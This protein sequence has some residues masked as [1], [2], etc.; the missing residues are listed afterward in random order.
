MKN[1]QLWLI[2]STTEINLQ[3]P[4][5]A[6]YLKPPLEGLTGL[7]D[8]RVAQGNN[9]GKSGGWTG[10]PLYEPR[11]IAATVQ[12]AHPDVAVV[13]QKR[14]DLA[15]LLAEHDLKLR[16]VTEGGTTY[17]TRVK[18]LGAPAPLEQL[19]TRVMIK[20]N[21]KADDPLLYDYNSSGG[22]IV[23]TLP[24]RV[25]TGGF[26]IPFEF[27]LI[28]DGG[29][30]T[31]SVVNSGTSTVSPIITLYGP[32]HEPKVVNQTTNQQIQ[33]LADLSASDVVVMNTALETVTLNGLDIY[34]LLSEE[35]NFI[36]INA[37][38]NQMYLE[39]QNAGDTG[40]AEIEYNSG[41]I[42]T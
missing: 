11:F 3:D 39:S 21:L 42:G 29:D 32:L 37:G 22:G 24:V 33:I 10:K 34:Y 15:T 28:I 4:Q 18:V 36:D 20:V 23:A 14:R 2:G 30:P 40:Y 8:I 6:I 1:T 7:P 41:F 35:S 19:L 31:V 38:A 26:E 16:Y 13:E 17:T 5:N 27:P 9:V 12:I 25:P